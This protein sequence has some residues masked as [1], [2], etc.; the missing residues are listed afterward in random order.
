MTR[1][2]DHLT[3]GNMRLAAAKNRRSASRSADRPTWRRGCRDAT[4]TRPTGFVNTLVV[5][6]P[7]QTTEVS[8][9]GI[10]VRFQGVM[11]DSRCPADAFC[12]QGGD[13]I[14]RIEVTS[15]AGTRTYDLHTGNMQPA[16]HADV[17]IALVQLNP[18]P[19]SSRPI[20]PG[21]Y[22]ATFRVTRQPAN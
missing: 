16:H 17:T 4:P 5:L 7:G 12:I 9:A 11:G 8:G 19:F 1:N 13:A 10:R 3:Y 18:Y 20:A 2:D 21:E 15:S 22:R 14:V 6:A